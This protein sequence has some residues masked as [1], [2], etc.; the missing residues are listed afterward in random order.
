MSETAPIL[1]SPQVVEPAA[2]SRV[3]PEIN[4][5]TLN[6]NIASELLIIVATQEAAINEVALDEVVRAEVLEQLSISPTDEP[7]QASPAEIDSNLIDIINSMES[8]R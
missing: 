6:E 5:L 8:D 4:P 3:I 2:E 7:P 1:S